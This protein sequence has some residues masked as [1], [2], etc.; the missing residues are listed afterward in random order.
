M[1]TS[2]NAGAP[3]RF[4]NLPFRGEGIE[5]EEFV[6]MKTSMQT[7]LHLR[8]HRGITA[9]LLVLCLA[10]FRPARAQA[11]D[12]KTLDSDGYI[13]DWVMLGPIPLPE[14]EE[15][16]DAILRQQVPSESALRPKAGDAV[17]VRGKELVWRN[18]T[19]TTNFFDFNAILKSANDRAAG[20]MVTYLECETEIPNVVMAVGSNDQGRIYFNGVDIYAFTDSR[21]LML[22]ADKGKVTLK[23]GINVIVF[24]VIN[25][26]N[27][28]Q[29]AM[30][31]LD[32]SGAPLKGV[33]VKQAP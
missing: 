22:D 26:L 28:W 13:R 21:P 16:A 25:E 29:G 2:E 27:S 14:G 17:T 5:R 23:K 31:L 6:T 11:E 32:K 20:Y 18:I 7:R 10:W 30:R 19:A 8:Y 33:R 24:K 1:N 9:L 15:A 4:L 12:L 3:S